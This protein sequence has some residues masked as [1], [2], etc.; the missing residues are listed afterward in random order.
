L[1]R[2]V[3]IALAILEMRNLTECYKKSEVEN[4]FNI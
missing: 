4:N 1:R 2:Y 3:V